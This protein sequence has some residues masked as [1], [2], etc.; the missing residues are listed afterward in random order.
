MAVKTARDVLLAAAPVTAL[1]GTRISPLVRAQDLQ[2][3]A[4]TLQRVVVTPTN[5]LR[6][7]ANLDA[8]RVQLDAYAATYAAAR[9]LADAC[10]DA[11]VA[12][13]HLLQTEL[14]SYEPDV[15]PE[16]YRVTQEYLIWT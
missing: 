3:P 13:G 6:G 9:T 8:N 12:A 2:L 16:L 10:R 7:D 15:D 11:L 14:D 1:V 5:H 4:V